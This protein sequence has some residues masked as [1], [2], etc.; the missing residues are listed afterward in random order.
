M[1]NSPLPVCRPPA[2]LLAKQFS[3][4]QDFTN[5]SVKNTCKTNVD[6][7]FMRHDEEASGEMEVAGGRYSGSQKRIGRKFQ[8]LRRSML[9][10]TLKSRT[11]HALEIC[12]VFKDKSANTWSAVAR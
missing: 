4:R 11:V 6:C 2:L 5:M 7:T 12:E 10:G 8:V 1:E 3:N 9:C